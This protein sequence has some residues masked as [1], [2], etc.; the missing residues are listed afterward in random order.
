MNPAKYDAHGNVYAASVD[1]KSMNYQ[2]LIP[3]LVKAVQEQQAII[4]KQQAQIDALT[5]EVSKR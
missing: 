3:I 5:E 1:F 4:E 2:E